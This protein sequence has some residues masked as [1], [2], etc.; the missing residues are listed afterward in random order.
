[1]IAKATVKYISVAVDSARRIVLRCHY[2]RFGLNAIFVSHS[3][4]LTDRESTIG[5]LY[6]FVAH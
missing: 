3:R 2:L 4:H 1:M 6:E 5:M